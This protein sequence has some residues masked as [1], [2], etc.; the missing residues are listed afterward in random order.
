MPFIEIKTNATFNDKPSALKKI[1]SIVAKSLGKPES[2]VDVCIID[3]VSMSFG[4][5]TDTAALVTLG[6]LGCIDART[7]KKTSA[8]VFQ[9]LKDTI[10]LDSHRG[11]IYFIDLPAE[12]TG[13][14]GSTFA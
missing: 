10:N 11:Y 14:G 6:S 12:N 4:G 13:Y 7:N 2:Y 5:S 8:A 9:F 3:N 1:S